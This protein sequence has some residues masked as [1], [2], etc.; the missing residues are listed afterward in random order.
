[1]TAARATFISLAVFNPF[2]LTGTR[3]E[4]VSAQLRQIH[5]VGC[6][7][8]K[9]P[10]HPHNPH[11]TQRYENHLAIHFGYGKSMHVNNSAGCSILLNS[12]FIDGGA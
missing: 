3:G 4:E 5:I 7:G 12:R 10:K 2:S 11:H 8:T 1:M 6:P 9:I